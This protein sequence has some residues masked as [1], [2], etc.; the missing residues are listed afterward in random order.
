[1]EKDH[2]QGLIKMILDRGLLTK[3]DII[4]LVDYYEVA[5]LD[6]SDETH[7]ITFCLNIEDLFE[8]DSLPDD[9]PREYPYL[10]DWLHDNLVEHLGSIIS[11]PFYPVEDS[12]DGET[13]GLRVV[14]FRL[15]RKEFSKFSIGWWEIFH[16]GTFTKVYG[17]PPIKYFKKTQI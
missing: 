9:A 1:L 7:V 12:R 10:C 2:G 13:F 11:T 5:Q 15:N 16:E 4:S 8:S 17:E 6:L 14:F 3:Q